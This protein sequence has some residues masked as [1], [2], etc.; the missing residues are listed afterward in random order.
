[1]R[2]NEPVSEA[3]G[4]L[5]VWIDGRRCLDLGPGAT[6]A[7][8]GRGARWDGTTL[9]ASDDTTGFEGFRWRRDPGL[10]LNFFWLLYYMT[11]PT[12]ASADTVWF[13]DILVAPAR[14]GLGD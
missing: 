8:E 13:D 10:D 11:D 3:N 4:S 7:G 6:A 12:A 5:T 9:R 2:L 1:M 14:P